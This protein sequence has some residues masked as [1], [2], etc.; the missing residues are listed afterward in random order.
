MKNQKF[1]VLDT[2]K[3]LFIYHKIMENPCSFTIL[4]LIYFDIFDKKIEY[5]INFDSFYK[6]K[7]FTLISVKNVTKFPR[8][9][10]LKI[11]ASK[12]NYPS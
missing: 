8:D 4:F 5:Y 12:K 6:G 10:I 11:N 9:L 2:K 3:K 7:K 1:K